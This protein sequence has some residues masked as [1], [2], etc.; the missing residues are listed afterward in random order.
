MTRI[1]RT[2]SLSP[3]VVTRGAPPRVLVARPREIDDC[4]ASVYGPNTRSATGEDGVYLT[5]LFVKNF[6]N[7]RHLDLPIGN[8]VTC[9]IGENNSGKTN[10]FHALRLL[11]DG[12]FSTQRRRLRAEDFSVGIDPTQPTHVLIAAE[13]ADFHGQVNQ[14]ALLMGAVLQNGKA[15]LSYRFR[16]RPAVRERI[17]GLDA[18]APRPALTLE[19]YWWEIVGGGDDVDLAALTWD[20]PLGTRFQAEDLQQGF[21][22]VFME[23]LRDVE[24]RLAVART[25]PLQQIIEQRNI[26]GAERATLVSHLQVANDTIN[27]STTIATLG[28]NLTTAFK[29]AAGV[30]YGMDVALGLGEASFGDISKGLRVLLSGYGMR[31]LDPGRNGLGLNNVL[32][33][34]MLLNYFERRVAEGRTAGQLLLV[35]EPEAHLHPQLQRILLATLRRKNVQVFITAHSTHITSGVPLASQVVMTSGGTAVTESVSPTAIPGIEASDVADLERY[36]DATRSALLYARR[37]LLVEGP[38]ELFLIPGLVKQVSG[39][40]LDEAGIA[41]VPIFGTHFAVYARLFAPAGIPKKCAIVTDGDMAPPAE[42]PGLEDDDVSEFAR[43]DLEQLRGANVEVFRSTF[44]LE[45]EITMPGNMAMLEQASIEVGATKTLAAIRRYMALE[46]VARTSPEL[47]LV[48]D[49]TLKA[50][51][52]IGKARFAQ[53]LSKYLNRATEVPRYIGDAVAWLMR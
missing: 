1:D 46:G 49:R 23:A 30:S 48:R 14:E 26:P 36:L 2:L 32:F 44:T 20:E 28:D 7:F 51:K 52:A 11:L 13:F 43:Q 34:S 27:A 21:L 5:R 9:F 53:T 39:I 37:V 35:E 22:V 17:A 15:R 18:A 16:P 8:G 29:E 4:L 50:A 41:V 42:A 25:S 31:N 6:R 12:N 45:R 40:D 19:D 33:V 38:A 3:R 24:S 10:L 47:E